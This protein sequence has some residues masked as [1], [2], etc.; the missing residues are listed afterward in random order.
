MTLQQSSN[1]WRCP[2]L[3]SRAVIVGDAHDSGA[4][5]Q[6]LEMPMTLQQSSNCWRCPWLCSRAAI[7]GD[8]QDSAAEQQLLEMPR[9]LLQNTTYWT[10]PGLCRRRTCWTC[11]GKWWCSTCWT[12]TGPWLVHSINILLARPLVKKCLCSRGFSLLNLI[13]SGILPATSGYT[14]HFYWYRGESSLI[15]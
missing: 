7:V 3:W 12:Y 9:T 11:Q 10:C 14:F 15:F 8:I 2:D 6:L 5:Q 1:C 13:Y 4:E